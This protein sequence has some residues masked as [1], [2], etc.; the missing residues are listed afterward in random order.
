[1]PE[2]HPVHIAVVETVP[3]VDIPDPTHD[4]PIFKRNPAAD[5]VIDFV[6]GCNGMTLECYIKTTQKPYFMSLSVHRH[7]SLQA[8][9]SACQILTEV[10]YNLFIF[11]GNDLEVAVYNF[12][13]S[14]LVTHSNSYLKKAMVAHQC[15]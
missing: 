15:S 13:Q 6:A 4:G 14:D 12:Y 3:I 2:D 8:M 9:L 5:A 7:C 1:M 10:G 11:N